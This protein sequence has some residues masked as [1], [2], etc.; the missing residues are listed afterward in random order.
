MMLRT[1]SGSPLAP[2]VKVKLITA[3]FHTAAD[4][5]EVQ[6]IQLCKGAVLCSFHQNI[7]LSVISC[8]PL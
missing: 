4:L 8:K 2:S 3:G 7:L 6:P 1:V 5:T